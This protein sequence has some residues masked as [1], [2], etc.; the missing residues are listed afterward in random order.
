MATWVSLSLSFFSARLSRGASHS[1]EGHERR[2]RAERRRTASRSAPRQHTCRPFASTTHGPS[3]CK[4]AGPHWHLH[5]PK[6]HRRAA[7]NILEAVTHPGAK[8]RQELATKTG[9]VKRRQMPRV[10][11]LAAQEIPSEWSLCR[12]QF[13]SRLAP[14]GLCPSP[15]Y[16]ATAI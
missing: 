14:R 13:P 11:V 9:Q 16:A 10:R 15:C 4:L 8:I 12:P 6:T 7:P 5:A 2:P 1:C 3:P